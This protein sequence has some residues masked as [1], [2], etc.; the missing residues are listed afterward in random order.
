[1]G[2][3]RL[4]AL[5]DV[6][7]IAEAGYPGA[8]SSSWSGIVVPAGTPPAIVHKLSKALGDTLRDKKVVEPF[9]SIGSQPLVN[10]KED[11]FRKFIAEEQVKWAEVVRASGAKIN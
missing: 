7:T 8:Q 6:P 4:D 2:A 3:E 10:L 1:M 11:A 9:V 5:P